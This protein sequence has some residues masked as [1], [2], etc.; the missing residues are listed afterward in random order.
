MMKKWLAM[1]MAMMMLGAVVTGCSNSDASTSGSTDNST[2]TSDE[3]TS[4]ET[5]N[6]D[7]IK[8]AGKI[9]MAT[10]AAFP[11]FEYI[12]GGVVAGVDAD[13]AAEIAKDLGVELE[14]SD[15]EFDAI[16]PAVKNGQADFGA[17]GMTIRP[18]RQE[19]V[20]FSIEY[21]KS[22][23]YV[24]VPKDSGYTTDDLAD[25]LIGVQRG[26][27][28]DIYCT[29][30][31]KQDPNTE[32]V[33]RYSNSIIAAQ[34]LMNGKCDAVVIDQLPAESIVSQNSDKLELLPDPLTEE[35]YAIA[36][37]KGNT[38]LLDAINSTLQR[39]IDEGKID[40]L[41]EEHVNNASIDE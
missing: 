34:D 37:K 21:V 16:I 15:M 27:T 7:K 11:P 1:A 36:V 19:Q 17:A 20:D 28:G 25:L 33:M 30:E 26:T 12:S 6:I 10:N 35:S 32:E 41:V 13:I 14:I 31:I 23:Q 5:P 18:D 29:D 3:G 40:A 39:L 9:V 8:E 38:D 24:I 22:A 2:S 4:G